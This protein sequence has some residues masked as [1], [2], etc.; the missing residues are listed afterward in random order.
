MTELGILLRSSL[1]IQLSVELAQ[2][3][4]RRGFH[5]V[6]VTES[7]D[8]KDAFTQMAAY[9]MKTQRIHVASGI[10]PIYT[11]TPVMSGMTMLGLAELSGER[12][13]LGLG[14]GHPH[15]IETCHGVKLER[16]LVTMREYT[17]IVRLVTQ[18]REFSYQGKVFNIPHYDGFSR[19]QFESCP[20][21]IPIFLAALRSQM[22]RVAGELA[23][24]V[25]MNMATPE[26]LRRAA[27]IFREEARA[28]GRD[29]GQMTFGSI[30]NTSV[31]QDEEVAATAVRNAVAMYPTIM[32]FYRR[33][34][35]ETG[36]AQE[37]EAISPEVARG[38]VEAASKKIPDSMLHSLGA[39]GSAQQ[40]RQGLKV[41][42]EIGADLLVL[43]PIVPEGAD[44][45]QAIGDVI[46]AFAQ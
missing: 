40:A 11:R 25:L 44:T 29:P 27:G 35:R 19:S 20:F 8:S 5:S 1:P 2:E 21:H 30:V 45:G 43:H 22:V 14:T 7:A 18:Q 31:S 33:M 15:S 17:E 34:L 23:D 28:A 3:A 6:W 9:A 42:E 26:Y 4:E 10:T 37:M 16:P 13:I 39:F 46:Q 32:P 38:D 36:F 12:A 24:G 41:F